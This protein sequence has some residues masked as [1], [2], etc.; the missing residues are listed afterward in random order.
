M[1]TIDLTN[2]KWQYRKYPTEARN[3]LDLE[4]KLWYPAMVPGSI[5]LSLVKS[6]QIEKSDLYANPEK[7]KWVEDIPWIYRTTFAVSQEQL[8]HEKTFINFKSLDTYATIWI[9]GKLI[10]RTNNAFIAQRFEINDMLIEGENSVMVKFD[11]PVPT[12]QKKMEK[13]TKFDGI[14]F[15]HPYRVY[16][17][18]PQYSFGWDFCPS[19]PGCG[20]MD[21]VEIE[22]RNAARI[23]NVQA[24]TLDCNQ[25]YADVKIAVDL[26][27]YRQDD[28][29]CQISISGTGMKLSQD[30]T[31]DKSQNENSVVFHIERPFLWWP[32]GYGIQYL[33]DIEV[34]L[35]HNDQV[36]DGWRHK[37][38]IRT[39]KLE[40]SEN[41]DVP[42]F[43]FIVNDVPIKAKGANWLPISQ[44]ND[45]SDDDYERL[46]NLAQ[47]SNFNML[48]VWGG[49]SYERDIF[50]RLCDQFGILVW[51]D[52]M[53]ACGQYPSQKFFAD[54]IENETRWVV[55]R[56]ANHSCVAIWCGNNECQKMHKDK[57]LGN[58]RKFSGQVIFDKLIPSLLNELDPDRDY[59]PT[60]PYP[61]GKGQNNPDIGTTHNWAVWGQS[62][63]VSAYIADSAPAFVIE[64]GTQ[65]L[66][67]ESSLKKLLPKKHL[68][69]GSYN[70]EK[71]NY[72]NFIHD[73][74]S[75]LYKYTMYNFP[76]TV[77]IVYFSYFSQLA[78]ARA[79]K[80]YVEHNRLDPARNAGILYWQF[81]EPFPATC[82][83]SIDHFKN[84]KALH[85]Y[86]RR[87]YKPILIALDQ[88]YHSNEVDAPSQLIGGEIKVVN[89]L[90]TSTTGQMV[91]SL[92]RF[93]GETVD[94]ISAPVT[95]SPRS[96]SMPIKLPKEFIT[97]KTRFDCFLH[98]QLIVDEKTI[99]ENTYL[100]T[101]DKYLG[102]PTQNIKTEITHDDQ[103][104]TILILTS[105]VFVKDLRIAPITNCQKDNFIDLIPKQ[106]Q[107]IQLEPDIDI[108]LNDLSMLSVNS[109][110]QA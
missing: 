21:K 27:R 5:Y 66:P 10:G 106:P 82:W 53:F 12:A 88:H 23:E 61:L 69:P 64:F 95:V 25:H 77:S 62:H 102:L 97:D 109:A 79:A 11:P 56:L 110:L 75:R 103:N 2:L 80:L 4:E 47:S 17:R 15:R 76:P 40:Q 70:L 43:Q 104:K 13:Y 93:D 54:A 101:K 31:F 71:I 38:G 68:R 91:C 45:Q 96:V 74:N 51:Q 28:I 57:L 85:F 26:Q 98:L 14:A 100:L 32:K 84:P 42:A 30:L 107:I 58:N 46:L 72:N 81:N 20:I 87:F 18:K 55:K 63:D 92:K 73:P 3:L 41:S 83:S 9:N 24:R 78:Q 7:Y 89:D 50:Y 1:T 35:K 19:L 60:T 59:I 49:G 65:S 86:A 37:F 99:T 6:E 22:F 94:S 105:D 33:Y 39:V 52:F 90:A 8:A 44:L 67:D 29:Q 108:N 16:A 34:E 48:R 36:I